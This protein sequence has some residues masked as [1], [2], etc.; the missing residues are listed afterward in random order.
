MAR[1]ERKYG[2]VARLGGMPAICFKTA[3]MI[4]RDGT[5]T[6]PTR[7]DMPKSLEGSLT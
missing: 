1:R 6:L 7:A 4:I 5:L 2:D 3:F